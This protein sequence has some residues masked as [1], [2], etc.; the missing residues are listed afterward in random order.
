MLQEGRDLRTA[1]LR[2]PFEDTDFDAI[3]GHLT[4]CIKELI[5]SEELIKI[6]KME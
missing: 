3:L 6:V 5:V 4:T 1:H 2:F